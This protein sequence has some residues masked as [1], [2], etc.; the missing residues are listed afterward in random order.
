MK[1]TDRLTE[2]ERALKVLKDNPASYLFDLTGIPY[3]TITR[4]K[5]KPKRLR[6]T[7]WDNVEKLSDLD[8]KEK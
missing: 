2:F 8:K 6:K 7:S 1:F 5:R 3:S 4:L